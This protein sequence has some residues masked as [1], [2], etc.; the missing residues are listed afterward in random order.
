[1]DAS[2]FNGSITIRAALNLSDGPLLDST[3]AKL[4]PTT[5][6]LD[7]EKLPVLSLTT[8]DG[9]LCVAMPTANGTNCQD[10]ISRKW[11]TIVAA[12]VQG[13]VQVP[14]AAITNA[15]TLAIGQ[16]LQISHAAGKVLL[17]A[18]TDSKVALIMNTNS[19]L[20]TADIIL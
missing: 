9:V 15:D 12:V 7:G 20:Q 10:S 19:T 2:F 1:M 8:T 17:Q 5:A 3:L 14:Y 18:S 6:T 11:Y 4:T 16:A 13:P